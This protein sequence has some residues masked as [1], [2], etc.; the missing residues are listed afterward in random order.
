MKL[1]KARTES[2]LEQNL[3]KETLIYDLTIDKAFNLNETLSV[4]YK[5]CGQSLTFYQLKR[6]SKFT[7]D[8]IYLALDELN[9]EN[10]L[11]EDYQS[12]FAQTSRREVIKKVGLATMFAL[13]L[14]TGL[15]APKSTNAASGETNQL[16]FGAGCRNVS[17]CY[18]GLDCHPVAGICC[19]PAISYNANVIAPGQSYRNNGTD[20]V[21]RGTLLGNSNTDTFCSGFACCTGESA[22]GSCTYTPFN[23]SAE[24]NPEIDSYYADCVCTCP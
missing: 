23:E 19:N 2:L 18:G 7:D 20:I 9:R 24:P 3:E 4:V 16:N 17:S 21:I 12:P 22:S 11:A 1:P 6:R 5:A 13:P 14:I 15:V 8:F 10:L